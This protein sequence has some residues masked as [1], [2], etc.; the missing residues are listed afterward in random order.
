MTAKIVV[1]VEDSDRSKNAVA[2]AVQVARSTGAQ[3]VLANAYPYDDFP[4]RAASPPMQEY[5]RQDAQALLDAL[6]AELTG[7]GDI[8]TCT[9]PSM[10]PA[11]ALHLLA[12]RESAA[13]L[14]IGSSRRGALGRVF[15]GTTAASLLHGSPCP[16]AIVPTALRAADT[17]IM[18]IA[19]AYDGS[20]E[21][22]HAVVA[23]TAAARAFGA[24][25]RLVGVF[26]PMIAGT[27]ALPIPGAAVPPPDRQERFREELD[28]AV[29]EIPDDV[30]AE[31]VFLEGDPATQLTAES[32]DVDVMF[33]GSRGYGPL[34]AVLAGSVTGRLVQRAACPVVVV[35][36]G[37][38]AHV[39]DLFRSA[40]AD[41]AA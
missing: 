4:S 34:R 18:T 24:G 22:E 20:E 25:L 14:V 33:A 10:S 16:V 38:S 8:R 21:S 26:E 7:V 27:P 32:L 2:F 12:E 36:R 6:R 30:P 15:A 37:V 17:P 31:A 28:A 29:N 19:A 5:L 1:G 11:R 41:Q 39:E 3:V 9:I 13:L 23:A 40:S 35:P